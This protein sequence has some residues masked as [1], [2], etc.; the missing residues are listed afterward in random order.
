VLA[1]CSSFA[2]A[3]QLQFICLC[4]PTAVHLLM[5]ANFWSTIGSA[6]MSMHRHT[7]THTRARART[8]THTHTHTHTLSKHKVSTSDDAGDSPLHIA[9]WKNQPKI[10]KALLNAGAAEF[11]NWNA[12]HLAVATKAFRNRSESDWRKCATRFFFLLVLCFLRVK[13]SCDESNTLCIMRPHPH[14]QTLM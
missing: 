11:E 2:S 13:P 10:L 1:N 3:G 9:I 5:Q 7:H 12:L 8:H 4:W 14:D 6:L